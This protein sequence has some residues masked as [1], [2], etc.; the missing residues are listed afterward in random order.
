MGVCMI[1]N[2][3]IGLLTDRYLIKQICVTHTQGFP[4]SALNIAQSG[5]ANTVSSLSLR[6]F[7]PQWFKMRKHR[8]FDFELLL[9]FN[10]YVKLFK[11]KIRNTQPKIIGLGIFIQLTKRTHY[12]LISMHTIESSIQKYRI[13]S[14]LF[15]IFKA[16]R[17][18]L[19]TKTRIFKKSRDFD[20]NN[21][22]PLA[23]YYREEWYTRPQ[24]RQKKKKNRRY[25]TLAG[26]HCGRY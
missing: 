9:K 25:K 1:Y 10:F 11:S 7:I 4:L 18:S 17:R 16:I 3:V 26:A 2:H 20:N 22:P 23:R 19:I 8:F 13:E 6:L 5:R 21:F 24:H 12:T 14:L 15:V